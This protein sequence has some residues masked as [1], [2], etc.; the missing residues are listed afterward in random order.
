MNNPK[1][2]SILGCGWLGLPLAKHFVDNEYIVKGST[3]SKSKKELLQ[4]KG[5]LPYVFTLGKTKDKTIYNHFLK[6]SSFV[7]IS[8]PPKKTDNFNSTYME[9]IK[10]ILPFITSNKKIIFISST[11]V[12]KN[13]NG[14]ITEK[15]PPKPERKSGKVILEAENILKETFKKNLTIIRFSGLI[16]GKRHPGNFLANKKQLS[17]GK[18]PI[19]VIHLDDCIGLI[20]AVITK[21][22]WGEIFNGSVDK[23]PT[24]EDFY[25]KAAQNI[26][27]NPPCFVPTND[28]SFKKIS[29]AKSKEMLSYSYKYSNPLSF[30]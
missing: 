19:N 22:C 17:N 4:S 18:S 2:I 7:I 21:N 25:T 24:R 16:G 12:Y 5:I 27:N 9:E 20:S 15:T 10:S 13:T 26:G 14:W 29:N 30:L 1:Q 6:E 3:T 8:F 28:V 11:S 23:H